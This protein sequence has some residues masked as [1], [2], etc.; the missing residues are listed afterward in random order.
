MGA[1]CSSSNSAARRKTIEV[2]QG[3]PASSGQR[4]GHVYLS[5]HPADT[6]DPRVDGGDGAACRVRDWLTSRGYVV[7]LGELD[8]DADITG[9]GAATPGSVG[10]LPPPRRPRGSAGV[11]SGLELSW[12]ARMQQCVEQC[13]AF[14][15]LVS[16]HYGTHPEAAREV[17]TA[18]SLAGKEATGPLLPLWHSGPWPPQQPSLEPLLAPLQRVPRGPRPLCRTILEGVMGELLERLQAGG[19]MPAPAAAPAAAA[20]AGDG[21]RNGGGGSG[22]SRGV[23]AVGSNVEAV[24]GGAASLEG[25]F[26]PGPTDPPEED[27]VVVRCY[28]GKLQE[29][30][31]R[32]SLTVRPTIFDLGGDTFSGDLPA[33]ELR[34]QQQQQLPAAAAAVAAAAAALDAGAPPAAA[35]GTLFINRPHITLRNGA[36]LLRQNQE[37]RIA[38][39]G[40]VLDTMSVITEP[41]QG[42]PRGVALGA[43]GGGVTG[44]GGGVSGAP[45]ENGRAMVVVAGAVGVRMLRCQLTN[46]GPH[47]V[48]WL[49]GGAAA[50]LRDC[51][52]ESPEG[53]GAWV[54]DAGSSLTASA[55]RLQRCS[56][57]C[58]ALEAGGCGRL[59][60]CSVL[61]SAEHNG[62]MAGSG[63]R[64][65][66]VKCVVSG[67]KAG[68]NLYGGADAELIACE[69]VSNGLAGV[70]VSEPGS[71][72]VALDCK[73]SMNGQS[74]VLVAGG[75]AASLTHCSCTGNKAHGV[76]VRGH[77]AEGTLRQTTL[78]HNGQ[79][80]ALLTDSARC[81]LVGCEATGNQVAGLVAWGCGTSAAAADCSLV[82]NSGGGLALRDG[83]TVELRSCIVKGNR[84]PS[85]V[86]GRG[87]ELRLVVGAPGAGKGKVAGAGK[88]VS[89]G[90]CVVDPAPRAVEGGVVLEVRAGA[91]TAAAE[92]ANSGGG[93]GDGGGGKKKL[94][95]L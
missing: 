76:L 67:S 30:S 65:R 5:Y 26:Q 31:D 72:L 14:V 43:G 64:L 8:P 11:Q 74:G 60:G 93:A 59:E 63:A 16:E 68:V 29:L 75:G 94:W 53:A 86:T 95:G 13:Q 17:H 37:L 50:A 52:L 69:V 81:Q 61:D 54:R 22:G 83:A 92:G 38:G 78:S 71:R 84:L 34:K 12:P 47:L 20:T 70:E 41:R 62:V 46:H 85:E 66:A 6:G 49:A 87:S 82:Q 56:G 80:G 32:I 19:C 88:G 51:Q 27:Y 2:L 7:I 24:A 48:L 45:Y 91:T 10:A 15:A 55:C 40:V 58:L 36:L 21:V 79:A 33:L 23:E 35:G 18:D 73:I 3:T 44:G 42:G 77:G 25:C 90:A 28:T 9:S 39:S 89:A 57:P 1:G 4:P